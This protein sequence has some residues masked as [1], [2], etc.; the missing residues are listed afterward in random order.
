MSYIFI[1]EIAYVWVKC[2][3]V[4]WFCRDLKDQGQ[5]IKCQCGQSSI[6]NVAVGV[7]QGSIMGPLWFLINSNKKNTKV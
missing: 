4:A 5:N 3:V 2:W 1:I 6:M 7:S